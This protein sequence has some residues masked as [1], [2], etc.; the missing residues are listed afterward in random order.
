M[1][2]LLLATAALAAASTTHASDLIIG[3]A[4]AQQ[5]VPDTIVTATRAPTALE[6]VPAAIT[7]VTRQQI[8]ERGHVTLADALAFV[9]GLRLVQ[10]AAS[11]SR[12]AC[13]CAATR[14]ARRWC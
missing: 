3:S 8:E 7:V 12:P 6:R 4:S 2:R 11:A 10:A 1:R 5:A 9:P 14:R 13:S